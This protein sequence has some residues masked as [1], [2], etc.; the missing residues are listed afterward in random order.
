MS[1]SANRE[2]R[3]YLDDMIQFAGKVLTYTRDLD[4]IGLSRTNSPTM[5]QSATWS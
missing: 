4:Q 3:F 1:E 5:A 2:W